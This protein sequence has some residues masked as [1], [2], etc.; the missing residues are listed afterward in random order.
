MSVLKTNSIQTVNG[1]PILNSTGSVIQI[2]STTKTDIWSGG[3][4]PNWGE[5]TGLTISITPTSSSNKILILGQ[6][7]C[8]SSYWEAKGRLIRNGAAIFNALGSPRGSRTSATFSVN[9]YPATVAGYGMYCANINFLDSPATTAPTTYGVQM[10]SYSS[11]YAVGVNYN[12]GG[13]R[14]SPDYYAN[15]ISTLTAIEVSA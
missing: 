8:S 3:V 9:E 15:N 7:S 11:P 4:Y 14:D 12:V 10:Q 1:K 6:I 5:V 2:V 13:D